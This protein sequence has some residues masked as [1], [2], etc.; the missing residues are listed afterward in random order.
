MTNETSQTERPQTERGPKSEQARSSVGLVE[1][2]SRSVP[3]CSY[4][5][6]SS[7]PPAEILAKVALKTNHPTLTKANVKKASTIKQEVIKA[8]LNQTHSSDDDSDSSH[9][10][11]LDAKTRMPV[12]SKSTPVKNN[13]NNIV[14]PIIVTP[15]P[16]VSRSMSPTKFLNHTLPPPKDYC[17]YSS[18][19]HDD[20]FLKSRL[21]LSASTLTHEKTKQPS[22]STKVQFN[23]NT[24]SASNKNMTTTPQNFNSG[25]AGNNG[26]PNLLK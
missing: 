17:G 8:E 23:D 21:E 9:D 26:V 16:R 6:T 20:S 11:V 5:G 10:T 7:G 2:A 15:D 24:A 4:G 1:E 22:H 25:N 19:F 14:Q 13:A 12:D 3:H 18:T